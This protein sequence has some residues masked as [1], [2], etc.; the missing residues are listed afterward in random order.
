MLPEEEISTTYEYTFAAYADHQRHF[1]HNNQRLG[2]HRPHSRQRFGGQ[3]CER[4]NG[5]KLS[6]EISVR[7]IGL[8]YR[9]HS[10]IGRA[11]PHLDGRWPVGVLS[12]SVARHVCEHVGS[13]R[14]R[15]HRH[16]EQRRLDVA[17]RVSHQKPDHGRDFRNRHSRNGSRVMQPHRA[18]RR[19]SGLRRGL[20]FEPYAAD[21]RAHGRAS[22]STRTSVGHGFHAR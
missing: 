21:V 2:G 10:R 17:R 8:R 4:G 6:G 9:H 13:S 22:S 11:A 19:S 5:G 7:Q 1:A 14:P 16:Y 12:R 3:R 15:V 18:R 20:F